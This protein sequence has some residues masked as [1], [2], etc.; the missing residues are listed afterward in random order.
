MGH[1]RF[2][3]RHGL[4]PDDPEITV[5]D[6]AP[7]ELRGLI[8]D[9]ADGSD[10]TPHRM[11]GIVCEVLM[12]RPDENNW[13]A[14]PNVDSE[15]R[16]L[17]DNCEWYEVYDVIEAIIEALRKEED[18]PFVAHASTERF[19]ERFASLINTYFV[20]RG[21]GYQ[22]IDGRIEVRGP[23]AFEVAVRSARAQLDD[24]GLRTAAQEIH[25]ALGDLARRPKPDLTGATQHAMAAVECVARTA[26][27][28]QKA[29]LG[30]ILKHH[31]GL[32]PQPLDKGLEKM[33]GYAS[34]TARHLQEGQQPSFEEAQLAVAMAAA[35]AT[36]LEGKLRATAGS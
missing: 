34:N 6:D 5:R 29:T 11:R 13:S 12:R 2:S 31:P 23:E 10:V 1:L 27:G 28:N 20:K 17:L 14:Y 33:W 19:D 18:D 21:I 16:G 15:V 4:T 8:V 7:H 24:A 25:E 3:E 26:V 36:Y 35:V 32:V 30:Q 22:V 9:F